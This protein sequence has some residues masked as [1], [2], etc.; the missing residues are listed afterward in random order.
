MDRPR[1][2]P[3]PLVGYPERI[4]AALWSLEDTR[5]RTLEGLD[6][7]DPTWLDVVV[8]GSTNTIAG[9]L[10]HVAAIELDWLYSE[11]LESDDYPSDIVALFPDDVRDDQGQLVRAAG[12]P[13]EN[14]LGRLAVVRTHFLSRMRE[15]DAGDFTR[16]RS[17]ESYDVTPEWVIHHLSQHEAEHR[18]QIGEIATRLGSS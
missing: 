16:E 8:P 15:I 5:T 9:L 2:V 4:A 17:L 10:Y 14:H 1:F 7:V 3:M 11:I 18:G 12:E 6:E 13:V